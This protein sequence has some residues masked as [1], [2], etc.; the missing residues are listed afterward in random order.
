MAEP[1]VLLAVFDEVGPAS[2]GIA[3]L[4]ELGVRDENMNVISGLPFP[5]R[6]LG[7]PNAVTHVSKI[8]LAGA[9]VGAAFG[10]FLL[11]GLTYFYPLGVGGQPL[12]PVPMGFITTFEMAMLGLMGMAFLGLF[13]DSGFPSY[14]P[15][16][17]VPEIS[18]GKVALLLECPRA[19]QQRFTETL[20]KL[21]AESVEPAEA[22]HL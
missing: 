9:A 15:K 3:R 5:G 6:V 8:A 7:R 17:Y 12:Y 19:E 16:Q 22:R 14:T 4:R 1:V 21:G 13:V 2:N 18:N 20:T 11:Y 10:L